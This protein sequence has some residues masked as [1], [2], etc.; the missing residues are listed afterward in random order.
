MFHIIQ[1]METSLQPTVGKMRQMKKSKLQA[2][3]TRR[4]IVKAA[5]AEFRR[6]GICSTGLCELMAAAGLTH[7]RFCGHFSSKDQLVAEACGAGMNSIVEMVEAAA[8]LSGGRVWLD[9]IAASY[10][11]THHRENR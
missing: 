1:M 9:A 10:L 8:C 6:N 11:S 5:A 4:R 2:A 3:E 7:G